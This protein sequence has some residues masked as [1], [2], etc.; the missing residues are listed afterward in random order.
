MRF[1][2]TVVALAALGYTS[3]F[4]IAS[5]VE[6][7]DG[8]GAPHDLKQRESRSLTGCLTSTVG[9]KPVLPLPAR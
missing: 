8:I 3:F 6:T 4:A 7:A 5:P 1:S 9:V 2:A